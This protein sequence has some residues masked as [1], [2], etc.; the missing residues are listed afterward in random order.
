MMFSDEPRFHVEKVQIR[1]GD[2]A[3]QTGRVR[4]RVA[5]VAVAVA[6]IV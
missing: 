4:E 5:V 6:A 1:H 3:V 2:H